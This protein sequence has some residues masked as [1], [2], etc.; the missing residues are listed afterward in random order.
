MSVRFVADLHG[1]PATAIVTFE[2]LYSYVLMSGQIRSAQAAYTFRADI[3]G[4]G[5][6]GEMFD[7]YRR[8]QFRIQVQNLSAEGFVL[9]SNPLLSPTHYYF[10]RA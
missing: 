9:T 4:D 5:G 6:Y 7:E 2:K 3:Y 8:E 1:A 10:R